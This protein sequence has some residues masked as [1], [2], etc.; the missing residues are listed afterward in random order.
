MSEYG[1]VV[2]QGTVRFE[3]VFPGPV[4][5]VWSYLVESEKRGKWLASGE[6]DLRVGGKVELRFHHAD[7]TPHEEEMPEKY[8][9]Y[10]GGVDSTGTILRCEPPRLLSFT[11][12]DESDV[13]F[14]LTPRGDE[15]LFVL[16]H[17]RLANRDAM[18]DV[19]GGWHTHLAILDDRLHD[20]VPRPFW[21]MHTSIEGH[22]NERY[23]VS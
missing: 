18:V 6:M 10:E 23:P 3:R 14:E 19:S 22:Y 12:D 8:K 13:T 4:E 21:A 1:E 9:Q 16:T 7:L 5:R 15:V 17:S 2:A 20:R 11:W